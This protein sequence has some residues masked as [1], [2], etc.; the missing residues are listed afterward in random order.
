MSDRREGD[1]G[2]G[3]GET[4]G[5]SVCDEGAVRRCFDAEARAA[6]TAA[7]ERGRLCEAQADAVARGLGA[8]G[9]SCGAGWFAY[10]VCPPG[11]EPAEKYE[12][13]APG[14]D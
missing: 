10:R 3:G 5:R 12:P 14:P 4:T 11:G 6:W 9:R 8:F 7:K 13:L 1:R 2:I